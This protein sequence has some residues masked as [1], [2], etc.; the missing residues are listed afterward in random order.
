MR[1]LLSCCL[2]SG[3]TCCAQA[4]GCVQRIDSVKLTR[5]S[6]L[7]RGAYL[8]KVELWALPTGTGFEHDE[9]FVFGRAARRGHPGPH[10]TWLLPLPRCNSSNLA[11]ASGIDAVAFDKKGAVVARKQ[12][13]G[14]GAMAVYDTLCVR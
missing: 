3:I 2:F 5:T 4:A 14:T 12:L 9:H 8:N 1:L 11:L 7:I 10:E 6:I 13:P